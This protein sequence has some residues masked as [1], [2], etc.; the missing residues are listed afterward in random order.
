MEHPSFSLDR[1][2]TWVTACAYCR[3]DKLFPFLAQITER[4]TQEM[5]ALPKATRGADFIFEREQV[6]DVISAFRVR[7]VE[8]MRAAGLVVF[9]PTRQAIEITT[10]QQGKNGQIRKT[11]VLVA[12]VW[13]PTTHTCLLEIDHQTYTPGAAVE[14]LLKPLFFPDEGDRP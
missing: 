12:L 1:V 9:E 6:G 10:T 5:Q 13:N 2:S 7:R 14:H 3:V 4:D 11:P 8:D